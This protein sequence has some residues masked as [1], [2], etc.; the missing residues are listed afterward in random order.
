M[1]NLKIYSEKLSLLL[2]NGKKTVQSTL[3][4]LFLTFDLLSVTKANIIYANH[5]VVQTQVNQSGFFVKV[6]S[7]A[8]PQLVQYIFL[9]LRRGENIN[10]IIKT[11]EN[12]GF[13]KLGEVS[14][15]CGYQKQC[16]TLYFG[17]YYVNSY[18][19]PSSPIQRDL[20]KIHSVLKV[21]A[22]VLNSCVQGYPKHGFVSFGKDNTVVC[23]GPY[24]VPDFLK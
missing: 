17:P 24:Y 2:K 21:N 11:M 3:I 14:Q 16:P 22:T 4:I 6:Q 9:Q 23:T 5:S 7:S 10:E 18:Q 20:R 13:H 19:D 15:S 8:N 1:I 12:S